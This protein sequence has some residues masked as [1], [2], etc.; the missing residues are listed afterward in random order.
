M[1]NALF[2]IPITGFVSSCL[3]Q[4]GCA[5]I[6]CEGDFSEMFSP[7]KNLA[8]QGRME[9]KHGKSDD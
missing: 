3:T 1:E 6:A 2:F 8:S 9:I 7:K 5:M 4:N